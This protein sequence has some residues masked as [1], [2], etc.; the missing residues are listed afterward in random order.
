MKKILFLFIVCLFLS[1]CVTDGTKS[2]N[3]KGIKGGIY[4]KE[5]KYDGHSYIEFKDNG[6]YGQGWVHNPECLKKDIDSLLN[7]H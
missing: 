7:N 6:T 2:L 4:V 3:D 5:I 1:S